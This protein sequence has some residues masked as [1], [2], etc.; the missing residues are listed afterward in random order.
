MKKPIKQM[1]LSLMAVSTLA[2]CSNWYWTRYYP[3]T[4]HQGSSATATT[5]DAV[6][7]AYLAGYVLDLETK[8]PFIAKYNTK[9]DLVLD[10]RFPVQNT[11]TYFRGIDDILVDNTGNIYVSESIWNAEHSA[12]VPRITKLNGQGEL[13]WQWQ[14]ESSVQDTLLLGLELGP[15]GNLFAS[16]LDNFAALSLTPAGEFR[17]FH[18]I[19]DGDVATE[20]PLNAFE[21]ITTTHHNETFALP[22]DHV[23]IKSSQNVKVFSLNGEELAQVSTATLGLVK[24]THVVESGNDITVVGLEAD[25]SVSARLLQPSDSGYVVADKQLKL[26]DGQALQLRLAP[27]PQGGFCF[28]GPAIW[29]FSSVQLEK[30][31]TGA[32]DADFNL[33]WQ[34]TDASEA[35]VTNVKATDTSCYSQLFLADT[36]TTPFVYVDN[37]VTGERQ[38]TLQ[39]PAGFFGTDLLVA[40]SGI[41]SAGNTWAN[42]VMTAMLNKMPVR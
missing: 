6:G 34:H 21:G 2:A 7:N 15:D 22:N 16:T 18:D 25:N 39:E 13:L 36:E 32:V 4:D 20:D 26:T 1:A 29:L 30:L 28:A 37:A 14:D 33:S 12:V 10:K 35:L 23:V 27:R 8:V 24:I 41:L 17:W 31:V 11:E 40:G 3:A 42:E 19:G 5:M 9:G 38:A